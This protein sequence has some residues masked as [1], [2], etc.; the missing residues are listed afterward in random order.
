MSTGVFTVVVPFGK[1]IRDTREE[2][3]SE[4]PN[5]PVKVTFIVKPKSV[6]YL[7]TTVKSCSPA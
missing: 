7:Q 3:L 1:Y 2:K 4:L 6:A 5:V